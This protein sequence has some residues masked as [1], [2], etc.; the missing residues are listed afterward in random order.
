MVKYSS[1]KA[2]VV[3]PEFS[4]FAIFGNGNLAMACFGSLDAPENM[5][6]GGMV[7]YASKF[8]KNKFY[9]DQINSYRN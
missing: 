1:A 4:E 7:S 3:R 9:E 2:A 6:A 8:S 5:P